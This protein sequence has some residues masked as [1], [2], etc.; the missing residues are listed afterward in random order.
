MKMKN[1]ARQTPKDDSFSPLYVCHAAFISR[2]NLRAVVGEKV[3][4][5]LREKFQSHAGPCGSEIPPCFPYS[6]PISK[7]LDRAFGFQYIYHCLCFSRSTER[8]LLPKSRS[9]RKS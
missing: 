3:R 4:T 2:F 9:R 8:N 5:R 7:N 6:A 1:A